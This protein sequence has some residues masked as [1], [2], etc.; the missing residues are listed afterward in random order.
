MQGGNPVG[1]PAVT[2]GLFQ[3][4]AV[5]PEQLIQMPFPMH[6]RIQ[7]PLAVHA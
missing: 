5:S 7:V 3:V 6:L 4:Q 1:L 2:P